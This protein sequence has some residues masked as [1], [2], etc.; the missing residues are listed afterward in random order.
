MSF[1][2]QYLVS[3]GFF[4]KQNENQKIYLKKHN[5]K[6]MPDSQRLDHLKKTMMFSSIDTEDKQE[7]LTAESEHDASRYFNDSVFENRSLLENKNN[8][9]AD[10]GNFLHNKRDGEYTSFTIDSNTNMCNMRRN[11]V[12]KSRTRTSPRQLEI[13]EEVCRTTLK[14]NKEMRIRLARELNMTERQVQIW[15][16]NKR[17]KTKKLIERGTYDLHDADSRYSHQYKYN[18]NSIYENVHP[19]NGGLQCYEYANVYPEY[20]MTLAHHEMNNESQYYHNSYPTNKLYYSDYYDDEKMQKGYYYDYSDRNMMR[21][22]EQAQ[23]RDGEMFYT[24]DNYFYDT[25]DDGLDKK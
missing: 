8:K 17:A 13:L 7:H 20:E 3:L 10:Q 18:S 25:Y 9:I 11:T 12:M 6:G 19:H 1:I 21:A 2:Y 5:N 24:T 23:I 22:H 4:I 16:Q 14:P 15:F